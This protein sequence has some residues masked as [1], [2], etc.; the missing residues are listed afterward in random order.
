MHFKTSSA[1][2]FTLDQSKILS[3]GN[4]LNLWLLDKELNRLTVFV[5]G[6]QTM[7]KFQNSHRDYI[8][9]NRVN[10]SLL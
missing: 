3:S 4:G 1:I 6:K 2:Y 9:A 10:V 8:V 7:E 5:A